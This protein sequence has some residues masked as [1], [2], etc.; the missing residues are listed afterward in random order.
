MRSLALAA[1]LLALALSG[2]SLKRAAVDWLGD[3]LAEGGSVYSR[4]KD[5]ELVKEALPFALKTQE[6]L[7]AVSP[8]HR[9]LLLTTARGFATY[10]FLLRQEVER[11]EAEDSARGRHLRSRVRDLFLRG[12]DYALHALE[13]T[14]PGFR[15]GL[16]DELEA[17]LA[18]TTI[19]DV[20][21]LYWAGAGWAGA[22][23]AH[24]DDMRLLAEL[25]IAA[26]LIGRVLALDESYEAGAAHEFMVSYEGG[27][28]G[29]DK[30]LARVHYRRAV[31][32]SGGQRASVH[33]A[34]AETIAVAEQDHR[35]FA[36]LLDRVGALADSGVPEY[37]LVN[38][39]ARRRAAWLRRRMPDLFLVYQA[40]ESRQ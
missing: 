14:H 3:S 9:G 11:L 37:G 2:C 15:K 29:G 25:P 21:F 30:R 10:A 36:A 35:T 7:L 18:R 1:L 32:L 31:E 5:P 17:T 38:E 20:P 19:E 23:A 13:Q 24:K 12:R 34:L 40:S 33:L 16:R 22:L 4:D 26:A 6:S 28:P 39:V 8:D 27:R